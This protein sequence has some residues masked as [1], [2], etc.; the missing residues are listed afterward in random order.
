MGVDFP[1]RGLRIFFTGQTGLN[2]KE[3]LGKIKDVCGTTYD[4]DIIIFN[5]GDM[6]YEE[7]EK[8]GGKIEE[9]QHILNLSLLRLTCLRRSI[10]KDIIHYC[11]NNPE[12]DVIINSHACFRWKHGLFLAY[13]FDLLQELKID[14][15][16]TLIDDVDSV[17]YR[18]SKDK[19]IGESIS[20]KDIMVWREEEVLITEAIALTLKSPFYLI[21]RKNPINTIP[22]ILFEKEAKKAYLSFPITKVIDKPDIIEKILAFKDKMAMKMVVWDPI[23]IEERRLL[24]KLPLMDEY[25]YTIRIDV[26]DSEIE[27]NNLQLLEIIQDIDGQIISRDYKLINQSDMIITYIPE[28][29]DEP[30]I[31]A[32]CQTEIHYAYE[33]PKSVFILWESEKEHPSPWI[34][35]NATKLFKGPKMFED[36]D[37]YL[38]LKK[39]F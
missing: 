21:T 15:Y 2:K 28:V 5:V 23:T 27:L 25:N 3:Y 19:R 29:N 9:E 18:I 1:K 7:A 13:D 11:K 8:S 35:Q 39:Y 32:G 31:S 14:Y 20:L 33:L 30:D 10:L 17:Y 4:K 22:K 6:M 34:E 38:Q 26:L 24:R 37:E 36:L 16:F 12:K